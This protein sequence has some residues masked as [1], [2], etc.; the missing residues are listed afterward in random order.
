MNARHRVPPSSRQHGASLIMVL[1]VL[2]IVSLLGVAGIQI[3][4]MSERGARNDRDKLLAWQSAEAGL[5]DAEL[6]IFTP[7]LSDGVSASTR[8]T[9]FSPS[10]NLQAFVSGCGSSGNSIGL[11]TMV[12]S[13]KPAW[14]TVDFDDA[15]GS[16]K[17]TP[18]GQYTGRSFKAGGV[19]I[20]P[21]KAP[22]YIIEPIADQFGAGSTSRDLGSSETKYVYRVTSMGYGPRADIQ[23][24]VQMLYRN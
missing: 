18:Y 11:C 20:Q 7:A 21:Y 9:L 2:T 4:M 8:G 15:S 10:T 5:A 19:G 13:G 3:S 14:M 23:A 12:P 22:R 16:A 6:D 1:I 24:V 17:T